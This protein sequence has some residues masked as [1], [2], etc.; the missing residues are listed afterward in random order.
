MNMLYSMQ[1]VVSSLTVS[2]FYEGIPILLWRTCIYS[3]EESKCIQVKRFYYYIW[4]RWSTIELKMIGCFIYI[5]YYYRQ[6]NNVTLQ[7]STQSFD[8]VYHTVTM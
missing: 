6:W 1:I 8:H 7:K 4:L 5:P 2:W 3:S